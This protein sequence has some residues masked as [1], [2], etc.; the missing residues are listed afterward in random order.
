MAL[1]F[2]VHERKTTLG[3]VRLTRLVHALLQEEEAW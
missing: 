3:E 1:S 2:V